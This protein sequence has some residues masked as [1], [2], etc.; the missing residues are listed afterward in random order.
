MTAPERDG[1]L[2]VLENSD[3]P[4]ELLLAWLPKIPFKDRLRKLQELL[5]LFPEDH[6]ARPVLMFALATVAARA[7]DME[8]SDRL[9]QASAALFLSNF[10]AIAGLA[11]AK[12]T[13]R[14]ILLHAFYFDPALDVRTTRKDL[15]DF[16]A[17]AINRHE[18][19]QGP[20]IL[21]SANGL[22]VE[23]F[24]KS[25]MDGIPDEAEISSIHMHVV[26]PT[27]ATKQCLETLAATSGFPLTWTFEN[28]NLAVAYLACA[29]FIIAARVMRHFQRDLIISDL[30]GAFTSPRALDVRHMLGDAHAGLFEIAEPDEV[31]QICH[32]SVS[33]W[34]HTPQ[35]VLFLELMSRYNIDRLRATDQFWMLDQL[36]L[37]QPET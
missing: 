28:Q 5:P 4:L 33:Y 27:E 6:F 7:G 32:C 12:M 31:D 15:G 1:I 37:E 16:D 30:D 2:D 13:L 10:G 34:R 35:T 14:N 22:Y 21:A 17:S 26:N 29:R 20:V 23:Q 19:R 8:T 36:S 25:F 11:R 3:E 9:I 18:E 24:G